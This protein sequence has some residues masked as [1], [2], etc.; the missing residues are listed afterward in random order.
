MAIS[1]EIKERNATIYTEIECCKCGNIL[2][3]YMIRNP[4]IGCDGNFRVVRSYVVK[5]GE[6]YGKK[7]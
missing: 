6:G 7:Y 2:K 4:S 3:M 1:K 5:G